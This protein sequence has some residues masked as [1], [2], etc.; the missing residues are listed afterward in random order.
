M[1]INM[2]T[3]TREQYDNMS[4]AEKRERGLPVGGLDL[5]F[6]GADAFAKPMQYSG[7]GTSAG[8]FSPTI[9]ANMIEQLNKIDP[10]FVNEADPATLM[11]MYSTF[12]QN[13]GQF[14]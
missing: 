9:Y 12:A 11:D 14:Y 4:N 2:G 10:D 8:G 13:A 1:R 5:A 3:V 6:A 7:R